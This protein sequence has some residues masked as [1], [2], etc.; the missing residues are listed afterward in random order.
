[1][2]PVTSFKRTCPDTDYKPPRP[3]KPDNYQSGKHDY[4]SHSSSSSSFDKSN[5]SFQDKGY[6]HEHLS[7]PQKPYCD[8]KYSCLIANNKKDP[9]YLQHTEQYF[10]V[11]RYGQSCR[12]LDNPFHKSH[13]YHSKATPICKY[14]LDCQNMCNP[15]H[16]AKYHHPGYW[17]WM[18]VCKYG[19]HCKKMGDS[20]HRYNYTHNKETV[21]PEN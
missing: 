18:E 4:D 20:E 7:S 5:P 21:Y 6:D 16:R 19:S 12:Y 13:F 17:D 10:H 9:E 1:M 2:Q 3:P 14:G 11:C 8:N 15:E